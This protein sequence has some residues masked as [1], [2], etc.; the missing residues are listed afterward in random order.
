MRARLY[1]LS[2]VVV[3]VFCNSALA[4]RHILADA[5]RDKLEGMW[6]G[7]LL[8]NYAGRQV[9]GLTTV[10]YEGPDPVNKPITD[11]QV[12]W[13]T[14]LTGQYYT[15]Q[16]NLAGNSSK[17]LGDDDTCLEF[18]YAYSLQSKTSL[19]V[20]ERT[21]LWTDNISSSGLYIANKQAWYPARA[22]RV[23]IPSTLWENGGSK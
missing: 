14:I 18:L 17:W 12:Q 7:Q 13:G 5:Y 23:T 6:L 9:E 4:E 2:I 20:A 11:Y 8:G 10:L 19:S 21:T 22:C 1:I 3:L 16:G 15:K